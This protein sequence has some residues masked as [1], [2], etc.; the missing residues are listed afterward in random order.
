MKFPTEEE[1]PKEEVPKGE[2]S[3]WVKVV[4]CSIVPLSLI[5]AVGVVLFSEVFYHYLAANAFQWVWII[6]AGLWVTGF[7]TAIVM[8][9]L[10]NNQIASGMVIGLLI[11]LC[12]LAVS[13]GVNLIFSDF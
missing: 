1:V 4:L 11:G 3:F 2:T 8:M 9:I 13:C 6:A 5:S 10:G 12:S 7:V